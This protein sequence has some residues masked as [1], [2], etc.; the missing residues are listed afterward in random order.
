MELA[1]ESHAAKRARLADGLRKAGQKAAV[2][3]LPDS[4]CWL[5]NLRGADV[6]KNPVL[7]GFA[8]LGDDS[9]VDLFVDPA[10]LDDAVRGASRE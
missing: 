2:I 7:H 10:K 6:P 4:L 8:V 9:H 3:T 1:G 5:V